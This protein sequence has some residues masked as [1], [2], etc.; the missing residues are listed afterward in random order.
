MEANNCLS[1]GLC[2]R[3]RT[4][5]ISYLFPCMSY[6]ERPSSVTMCLRP[7]DVSKSPDCD[8]V[9][10][11]FQFPRAGCCGLYQLLYLLKDFRFHFRTPFILASETHVGRGDLLVI[12]VALCSLAFAARSFLWL[13]LSFYG[14]AGL[15]HLDFPNPAYMPGLW[16]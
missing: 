14:I 16:S 15:P 10:T 6:R 9:C 1:I 7:F 11:F 3:M 5:F 2:S 12:P 8:E 13:R 4:L